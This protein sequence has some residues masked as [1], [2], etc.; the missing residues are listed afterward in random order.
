MIFWLLKKNHND[1]GINKSDIEN[2]PENMQGY[3]R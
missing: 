3:I 1:N 2:V